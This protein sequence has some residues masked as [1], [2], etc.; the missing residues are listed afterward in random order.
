[1]DVRHSLVRDYFGMGLRQFEIRQLLAVHHN[2]V[3]SPRQLQRDL[4][5]LQLFR[6][7]HLSTLADVVVFIRQQISESGM[8]LGYRLMH[9]KCLHSGLIVPKETVRMLLKILD[10]NG[11]ELRTRGRLH[12][13]QY[14]ASGP[15]FLWHMDG[16]D[17]LKPYGLCVHGCIDGYSRHIIWLTVGHTNNDPRV[18]SKYFMKA[19]T[20]LG[21]IPARLRSDM[22]TENGTVADLHTFLGGTYLYGTSQHNQRIESWW[23]V[24][25]KRNIQFWM[26]LFRNLKEDNFFTGDYVDKSIIQFCFTRLLQV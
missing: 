4:H 6:R 18:I 1:M 25:R 8:C 22:G 11:V 21:G 7:K 5:H 12:R 3:I 26:T 24:L 16:Y 15:N 23:A 19:V 10:P 14:H 2:L 9:L 20:D 13:R 17:K